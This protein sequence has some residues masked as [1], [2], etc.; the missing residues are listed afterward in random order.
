MNGWKNGSPIQLPRYITHLS[1][2]PAPPLQSSPPRA[3][4]I[5]AVQD[6][7]GVREHG[8]SGFQECHNGHGLSLRS[9][10]QCDRGSL[11]RMAATRH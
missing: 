9:A 8:S 6:G 7:P 2:A 4:P 5:Q 11:M 1:N 10:Q 3:K